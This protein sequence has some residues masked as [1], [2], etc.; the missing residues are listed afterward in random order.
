[1]ILLNTSV[2]C[3]LRSIIQISTLRHKCTTFI[4]LRISAVHV[5]CFSTQPGISHVFPHSS[6]LIQ[7]CSVLLHIFLQTTDVDFPMQNRGVKNIVELYE[8]GIQGSISQEC[9]RMPSSTRRVWTLV[10]DTS[11]IL[12]L[13]S[14]VFTLQLFAEQL[15]NLMKTLVNTG[16][17]LVI[18][19]ST[20]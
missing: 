16:A 13:F 19:N 8:W 5:P 3:I 1:M 2:W 4:Q 15:T 18:Q 11:A 12:F 9:P 6:L 20:G 14:D 7:E 17:S 10:H